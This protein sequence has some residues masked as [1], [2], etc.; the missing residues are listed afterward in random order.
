MP[1][2]AG[3]RACIG[4]QIAMLEIP[5]VIAAVLQAFELETPLTSIPV[6]A[7]SLSSRRAPCHSNCS[8]LASPPKQKVVTSDMDSAEIRVVHDPFRQIFMTQ[9]ICT[10]NGRETIRINRLVPLM[11]ISSMTLDAGHGDVLGLQRAGGMRTSCGSTG[12]TTL[13]RPRRER[14][15]WAGRIAP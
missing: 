13:A 11:I 5:I 8:P 2:G 14:R 4:M 12:L 15:R 1:F 10:T 7:G 9:N 3:P 6:H